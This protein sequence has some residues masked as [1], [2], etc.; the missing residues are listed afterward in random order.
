VVELKASKSEADSNS[1]STLGGGKR[2]I[3]VEL[4]AKVTIT[5][6]HSSKPK[7]Q[8]E[9]EHLFHSHMWVKEAPLHFIVDSG[10]QK[11]LISI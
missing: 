10:S 2:I 11:N 1:E 6:V 4:N 7:E 5:K 9:G 3:N 8:E